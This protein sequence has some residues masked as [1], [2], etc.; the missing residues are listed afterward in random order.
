MIKIFVPPIEKFELNENYGEINHILKDG[1]RLNSR[2]ELV[3]SYDECDYVFVDF[4]HLNGRSGY[5]G[6]VRNFDSNKLII[7]DYSD[8]QQLFDVDCLHY[9]KRSSVLKGESKFI[10]YSREVRPISYC[11]K[12]KWTDFKD[13]SMWISHEDRDID[14]S[15][16]FRTEN[17]RL[18]YGMT[19][20]EVVAEYVIDH[21]K[22]RNIWVGIVDSDGEEGRINLNRNYVNKMLRSKIV[23]NCNPDDWEGDYR[24]F[25]SLS[26]APM[27]L[28]DN[29]ITPVINPFK[30]RKHLV[31][32]NSLP[33]LGNELEYYL[34]NDL[35]RNSIASNGHKY[36]LKYH[37][38]SNRIDEILEII[39][40]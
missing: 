37:K 16:F 22:D 5:E 36:A 4:R 14:I 19:N 10:H 15:V 7:V 11:I 35:E 9:F 21:F 30:N 13:G 29:M 32:Y 39:G 18:K 8:Q 27:V 6:D 28:I 34:D 38:T 20:R 12:N 25:E 26:C 24:L 40:R 3:K 23:V 31:Y 17:D 33:Q 2:T 1:I